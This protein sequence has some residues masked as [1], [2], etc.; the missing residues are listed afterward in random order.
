MGHYALRL[1]GASLVVFHGR[2]LWR[3]WSEG[4]LVDFGVIGQWLAAALLLIGL[5][6]VRRRRGSVFR[7]RQAVALWTLVAVLHAL[8]GV[9]AAQ[10]L[11]APAPWLALP[12]GL[13][14]VGGLLYGLVWRRTPL[15]PALLGGA[16]CCLLP[17]TV[18]AGFA[19]SRLA[20]GPPS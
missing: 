1:A 5:L 14:A 4:S 6:A 19:G 18:H 16:N 15:S 20:R 9:P 3:H 13:V 2:L 7:G 12:L 10:L 17:G 8:A 11:A